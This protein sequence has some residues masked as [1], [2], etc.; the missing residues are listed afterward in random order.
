MLC[1]AVLLLLDVP[2][3]R[4]KMNR[5]WQIIWF[6]GTLGNVVNKNSQ[7]S[8]GQSSWEPTLQ[9]EDTLCQAVAPLLDGCY[10][11]PRDRVR[12]NRVWQINHFP[13]DWSRAVALR[14]PTPTPSLPDK[15]KSQHS[16]I[17]AV[18]LYSPVIHFSM[19]CDQNYAIVIK[20]VCKLTLYLLHKFNWTNGS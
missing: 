4:V 15:T 10:Y 18:K 11:V 7:P 14:Q 20:I 8:H 2:R 13:D 19:R 3:D 9:N 12:M 6:T 17:Y 16:P 5:V 1:L